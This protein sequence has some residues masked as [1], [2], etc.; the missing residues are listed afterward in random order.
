MDLA[1]GVPL[2]WPDLG[3]R[4]VLAATRTQTT[5]TPGKPV[6]SAPGQAGVWAALDVSSTPLA[7]GEG[8][9]GGSFLPPVP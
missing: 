6:F 1:L 4:G 7:W 5:A 2:T 9:L 8:Q 3:R